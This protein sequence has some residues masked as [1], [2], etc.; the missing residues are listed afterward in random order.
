MRPFSS[1]VLGSSRALQGRLSNVVDIN[2]NRIQLWPSVMGSMELHS[3][4]SLCA[5]THS[6]PSRN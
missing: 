5:F 6:T 4:P 1:S 3:E 2:Y